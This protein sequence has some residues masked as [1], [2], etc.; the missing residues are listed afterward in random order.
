S[1][2]VNLTGGLVVSKDITKYIEM[3]RT[4]PLAESFEPSLEVLAE[5]ANLFVIGPEA[6]R[7]RLRG[8][9]ALAGID[10]ADL[11][12]YIQMREDARSVGVQAVLNAM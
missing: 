1:Y 8:G 3:L 6:L 7:D 9:S 11:R 2:Q 5:I 10:K 12:P 4:F